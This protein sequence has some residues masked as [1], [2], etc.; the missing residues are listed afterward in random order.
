MRDVFRRD[1]ISKPVNIQLMAISAYHF[2]IKNKPN[3]SDK[4]RLDR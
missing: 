3:S 2:F 1:K 4:L